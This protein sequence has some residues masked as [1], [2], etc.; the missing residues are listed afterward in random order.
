MAAVSSVH[1]FNPPTLQPFLCLSG[2]PSC[3]C[4]SRPSG[5][6]APPSPRSCSSPASSATC[7]STASS[8]TSSR[9][10]P[11]TTTARRRRG[12]ERPR[13][14]TPD[15]QPPRL[16]SDCT[17]GLWKLGSQAVGA[18]RQSDHCVVMTYCIC[19]NH[20]PPP[21]SLRL[22]MDSSVTIL[23][24]RC[25]SNR[26]MEWATRLFRNETSDPAQ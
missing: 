2:C 6:S 16:L 14:P 19:I 13:P 1:I 18:A 11:P 17:V 5:S 24:S 25:V 12:S 9:W 7:R 8:P 26:P 20:A 4:V 21:P 15:P 23:Q 22:L 10:S 3:C